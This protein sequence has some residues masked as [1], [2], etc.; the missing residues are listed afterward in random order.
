LA[1]LIAS[2]LDLW[3]VCTFENWNAYA[4]EASIVNKHSPVIVSLQ[5]RD[6]NE[7]SALKCSKLYNQLVFFHVQHDFSAD[8]RVFC[9]VMPNSLNLGVGLAYFHYFR[10]YHLKT[11][12]KVNPPKLIHWMSSFWLFYYYTSLLWHKGWRY[13]KDH[14][15]DNIRFLLLLVFF[16]IFLILFFHLRLSAFIRFWTWFTEKSAPENVITKILMATFGQC[17]LF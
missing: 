9:L 5:G 17:R 8:L 4:N 10:A 11:F 3:N 13:C 2:C 16:F 14:A 6:Y 7:F 12:M 15:V 1:K